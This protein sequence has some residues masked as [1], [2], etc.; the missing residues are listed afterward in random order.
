MFGIENVKGFISDAVTWA[1][2]HEYADG[3][4]NTYTSTD[5]YLSLTINPGGISARAVLPVFSDNGRWEMAFVAE[6]DTLTP[7]A[8][9][10]AVQEVA[11]EH[12]VMYQIARSLASYGWYVSVLHTDGKSLT[13]KRYGGHDICVHNDLIERSVYIGGNGQSIA[14]M[15]LSNAG[16]LKTNNNASEH[17]GRYRIADWLFNGYDF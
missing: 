14:L 15:H 5:G 1:S 11:T 17:R 6:R 7:K 8:V 13:A 9:K 10:E 16:L 12:D 3:G 2:T 4:D